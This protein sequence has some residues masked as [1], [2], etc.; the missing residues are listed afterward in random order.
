[1]GVTR[2]AERACWRGLGSSR[3]PCMNSSTP[4]AP[5]G[6]RAPKLSHAL[7]EPFRARIASGELKPGDT[8]PPESELLQ[9]LRVSRP[10][11]RQALRVLE[12]ESL[13]QLGKGA[14]TGATVL[15]PS[16]VQPIARHSGRPAV[17]PADGGGNRRSS[18]QERAARD[19]RALFA[20]VTAWSRGAVKLQRP[21]RSEEHTSEL[22]SRLH[23]VCRLLLEK[24][25][26][27]PT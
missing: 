11:L 19:R 25:K 3:L 1:M 21:R 7:V 14:R 9:Q 23:L 12:S 8:L 5:G 15:Q 2:P 6:A 18:C 10:T 17:G 4:V 26:T 16:G 13:I 24:K 27:Q 20:L 22:Q